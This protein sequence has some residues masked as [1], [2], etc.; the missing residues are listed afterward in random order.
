MFFCLAIVAVYLPCAVFVFGV[1]NDPDQ[2][3]AKLPGPLYHEAA[4][5]FSIA[6][7][8]AAVL[9][10]LPLI[11]AQDLDDF[12]YGR[13]FSILFVCA[14]G[15]AMIAIFITWMRIRAVH[16]A[17]IATGFFCIPAFIYS[18][19]NITAWGSHLVAV[20]MATASYYFLS[21][22]NA[23]A[24]MTG[25]NLR[26]GRGFWPLWNYLRMRPVSTAVLFFQLGM[27]AYPPN[28]FALCI[29]PVALVLFS[30]LGAGWRMALA[31]RDTAFVI[32][33]IVFY[34][35]ATKFLYF[36]VGRLLGIVAP[37]ADAGSGSEYRFAVD[38]DL[39]HVLGK[40]LQAL[41]VSAD[42]WLLPNF[43]AVA[44]TA[45][46]AIAL[47]AGVILIGARIVRGGE[48]AAE[49]L[50]VAPVPNWVT[51][52]MLILGLLALSVAPVV[53]SGGGEISYRTVVVPTAIVMLVFLF[54]VHVVGSA[55]GSDEAVRARFE[56]LLLIPAV[57]TMAGATVYSVTATI[58]LCQNEFAYVSG[59]IEHARRSGN[60]ALV[61]FDSRSSFMP[62]DIPVGYDERR[63][64]I[65]PYELGCYSTYCLPYR[66]IY[67]VAEKSL[68]MRGLRWEIF[69]GAET[70]DLTCAAFAGSSAFL[71][72]DAGEIL[73]RRIQAVRQ[74]SRGQA[75]CVQ[76]D[77]AWHDLA[78]RGGYWS[79]KPYSDI[80][81][82]LWG[83][84][85][86][87]AG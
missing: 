84:L 10:H 87:K 50:S 32:G 38:L 31:L 29:F 60:Q 80:G 42:L 22:S 1:H 81:S 56:M 69:R 8:V 71:P 63:R 18:I 21:Q 76:Y 6:R 54:G 74:F 40:L 83:W 3:F 43:H 26:D 11:L 37:I 9:S 14:T 25:L 20:A 24:L 39:P 44:A 36:P 53:L 65:V 41:T 75:Y 30:R 62:H 52:A 57:A 86:P 58:K 35:V 13:I 79:G 51:G 27:L 78:W 55:L 33:N 4:H 67:A 46:A 23:H 59:L 15:G 85:L 49:S 48:Q 45:L 66:G 12:R 77:L 2:I 61:I 7:P 17:V 70:K 19:M 64:A 68:G 72:D 16:A 73:K 5:L 47:A 82:S 28:A 34:F